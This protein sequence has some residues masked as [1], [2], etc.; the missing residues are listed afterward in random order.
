MI[1]VTNDWDMDGGGREGYSVRAGHGDRRRQKGVREQERK[2]NKIT[3]QI[4]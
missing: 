4:T 2:K 1:A 3:N